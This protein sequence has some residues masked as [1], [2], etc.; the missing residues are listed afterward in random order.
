VNVDIAVVSAKHQM[1]I[2][3]MVTL[4]ILTIYMEMT[5]NDNK[6]LLQIIQDLYLNVLEDVP[7]NHYTKHLQ[8]SLEDAK[9]VLVEAGVLK[10]E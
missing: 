4:V 2:C 5:M 8:C 10:D 7:D 3:V 9:E 6:Y 1:S